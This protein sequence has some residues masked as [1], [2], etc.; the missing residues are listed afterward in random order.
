MTARQRRISFVVGNLNSG[1]AERAALNLAQASAAECRIVAEWAGGDLADDPLAAGAAVLSTRYAAGSRAQRT[2]RLRRHLVDE[3]PD[4]VVGML[5]PMVVT[6]AGCGA[7]VPVAHWLQAPLS[8]TTQ[9]GAR[10]IRGPWHR[11]ALRWVGQQS[12]V[13]MGATPGVLEECAGFGMPVGKL[14]LLPNGIDVAAAPEP[15]LRRSAKDPLSIVSVGR[16]EPQKRPDLLLRATALLARTRDVDL[17]LVGAGADE[18]RLKHLTSQLGLQDVVSFLGFRNRPM[19]VIAAADVFV[20]ATDHEGFGNVLVEALACG[21]PFV[22]S[23]VPYGPRWIR[24]DDHRLGVLVE[25]GSVEALAA[26]ISQLADSRPFAADTRAAAKLRAA[27]FSIDRIAASFD[28]L[29]GTLR[30]F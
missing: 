16:L 13:V 8:R 25:P 30:A 10:T 17:K 29:V 3:R 23:D 24:G 19:D 20:L 26:G 2:L 21:V 15:T 9:A 22:C 12:V 7:R 11:A 6:L 28:E 27:D 5:S 14:K 1:G 4:L 18:T